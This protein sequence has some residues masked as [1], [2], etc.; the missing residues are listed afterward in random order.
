MAIV[1]G[2]IPASEQ[3]ATPQPITLRDLA[4]V[5][6]RHRSL[7]ICSFV[8]IFTGVALM[9][10]ST[11]KRY[12]SHTKIFVKNER[13]D[14]VVTPGS[15]SQSSSLMDVT[16]EDLISEVELL[17][18]RDLL[19]KVVVAC[20]LH[21][22]R[23]KPS[24]KGRF[25]KMIGMGEP[26]VSP[27]ALALRA[28]E[29]NLSVE[30]I[31]KSHMIEISFKATDAQQAARI[32]QTLTSLYL[33]KHL[34]VH[35]LPGAFDFFK[36]QTEQYRKEL[37]SA[38]QK[39]SEYGKKEGVLSI[40]LKKDLAVRTLSDFESRLRESETA[41]SALEHRIKSL[42]GQVASTPARVVTQVKTADNPLL[43]QQLKTTLLNLQLKRTELLTK[44]E[45]T[46]RAVQEVDI[47][48]KQASEALA[49]AE[50]AGMRDE[51]TDV[52]KTRAWLD[53]ELAKARAELVTQKARSASL[54]KNVQDYRGIVQ[55]MNQQSLTYEDLNRLKKTAEENY[56]LYLRKQE[57]AR[58]SDA[59]DRKRIVNAAIAEAAT[60]PAFPSGPSK[61]LYLILG[62][63]TAAVASIGLAFVA[64]YIDPSFRTPDEVV[65]VLGVP[66][67]PVSQTDSQPEILLLENK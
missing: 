7:I 18:S 43:L 26:E 48:I 64:D 2:Q 44:Y 40:D 46:Y 12:E 13:T 23:S 51:T 67:L 53:E 36:Q 54:A 37:E 8:A 20:G 66:V 4:A 63:I 65:S 62:I 15:P 41:A 35:R 47:Q 22:Q 6:F 27:I 42:E 39:L 10:L 31:P 55:G 60:V 14:M 45:P 32:L 59:L 16:Q 24:L 5:L 17:K 30:P 25:K 21:Q 61:L 38:E 34:E 50:K 29:E 19:E 9:A 58:I 3:Q 56:M 52:D 57:E 28:V 33:E 1:E 11:P 49:Q